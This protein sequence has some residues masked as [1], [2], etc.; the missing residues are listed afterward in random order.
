[1]FLSLSRTMHPPRT[2]ASVPSA[3]VRP[4]K[5]IESVSG[6]EHRHTGSR[7]TLCVGQS[8]CQ[9]HH[10]SLCRHGPDY[11]AGPQHKEA[12]TSN[13]HGCPLK[14]A[15]SISKRLL[16]AAQRNQKLREQSTP[17]PITGL[18]VA[19]EARWTSGERSGLRVPDRQER[20]P[21]YVECMRSTAVPCSAAAGYRGGKEG[22]K[23]G[24]RSG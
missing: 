14:A 7:G 2:A 17:T 8:P 20:Y 6:G 9:A 24:R 10:H 4:S 16:M 5:P 3:S 1:M 18:S 19:T 11:K 23:E 13:S 21:G 12:V 22:R 15:G